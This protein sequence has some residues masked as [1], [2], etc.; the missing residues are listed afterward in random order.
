MFNDFELNQK[1]R[2]HEKYGNGYGGRY[3]GDDK[4]EGE[5]SEAERN[6]K[7]ERDLIFAAF[8]RGITAFVEEYDKQHPDK[9]LQ[10]INVGMG[11]NRLKRNV[12]ASPWGKATKLLTAPSEYS[13]NDAIKEQY[14]LYK[15]EGREKDSKSSQEK[16]EK[17]R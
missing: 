1:Y 8:Q 5:L 6:Q 7:K 2:E 17:T 10:Q 14:I 13:F 12:E 4:K 15:R 9:P 16:D 3:A 11:Y